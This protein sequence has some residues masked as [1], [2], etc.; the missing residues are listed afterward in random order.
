MYLNI[1]KSIYD[2]PPTKITLN[3]EK[4]KAFSKIR[5]KMCS[6]TTILFNVVLKI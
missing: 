3:S 5:N 1:V 6:L 4:L 2:K